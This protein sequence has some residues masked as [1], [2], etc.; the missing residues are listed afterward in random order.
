MSTD[1]LKPKYLKA[2]QFLIPKMKM[3]KVERRVSLLII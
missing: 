1:G 2:N 3:E